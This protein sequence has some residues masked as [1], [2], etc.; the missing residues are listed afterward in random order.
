MRE[1]LRH[2]FFFLPLV[3]LEASYGGMKENL[4]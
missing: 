1:I 4:T 3:P 2:Y